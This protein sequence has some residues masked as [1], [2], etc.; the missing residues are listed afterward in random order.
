MI[1][2]M[3]SCEDSKQIIL[4][5]ETLDS[6]FPISLWLLKYWTNDMGQTGTV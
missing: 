2:N 6:M 3:E 5:R 1:K 4:S